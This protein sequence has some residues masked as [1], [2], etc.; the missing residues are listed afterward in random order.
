MKNI[1]GTIILGIIF[2]VIVSTIIFCV[3]DNKIMNNKISML[4]EINLNKKGDDDDLD[5]SKTISFKNENDKNDLVIQV[6]IKKIIAII[7]KLF[8]KII[9][10]SKKIMIKAI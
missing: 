8:N 7:M 5:N 1:C 6:L 2:A 3:V 9:M 4:V 10:I